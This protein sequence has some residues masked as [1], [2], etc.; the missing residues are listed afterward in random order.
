MEASN[1]TK[2]LTHLTHR[3]SFLEEENRCLKSQ[4]FGRSSEKRPQDIAV[5]QQHLF[6]EAEGLAANVVTESVTIGAHQRKKTSTKKIPAGLPRVEIPHDIPEDEKFCPHDGTALVRIGEETSEQFHFIPA[7][8]EVLKHIR[9]KY[10]CPC[11]RQGVKIA[12]LPAHILPKSKASPSLLAHIV[13]AKYV[14]ALPLHRQ[15]AQFARL[16]VDLPR[17]TM[18]SWMVKLGECVV[19]IIN[20]MNE[21]LLESPIIQMDETRVQVLSSD[22]APTAEHWIWVRASGPPHRRIILFDY[23]PSRG[24]TVPMR[25]LEG[26]A[27]ILQTDGYEAYCAVAQAKELIHAGCYA[28]AR[29]RFEDARKAQ[30]DPSRDGQ[31]KI[32]LDLI[33]QLYRIEREIKTAAAEERLRVRQSESAP[34]VTELKAWLDKMA[35]AV[36]PQSALA[37]AVFYMLGHLVENAIRPFCIGRK[38]WLFSQTTAG[39]TASARLYSLVESA[40]ANGIE[41]HAYLS[42][43]FAE[44]PKATSGDHFESLLP[45]NIALATAGTK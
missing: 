37:K 38:N 23:N 3:V 19:P 12:P 14:D 11:C 41:P 33:G 29:R 27:G 28:H 10:G 15:E 7:T 13:T 32:A 34:I 42:R 17:A 18:A 8:M 22:K 31:S 20:L 25:L 43:L 21:L 1:L 30:V 36:L 44:L 2:E 35:D 26:F 4:L 5:E 45:W 6:N 16:G 39:A 24:G 40:K 9:F